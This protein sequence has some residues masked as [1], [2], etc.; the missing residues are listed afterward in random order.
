M[1]AAG[2]RH[3]VASLVSRGRAGGGRC[4]GASCAARIGHALPAWSAPAEGFDFWTVGRRNCKGMG[5]SH[6]GL[7][8]GRRGF[9]PVR[10]SGPMRL[11]TAPAALQQ[12]CWSTGVAWLGHTVAHGQGGQQATDKGFCAAL[13]KP[14]FFGGP[15]FRGSPPP[16]RRRMLLARLVCWILEHQDHGGARA[17]I[18]R[19]ALAAQLD[20]AAPVRFSWTSRETVEAAD[21]VGVALNGRYA[22]CARRRAH[23][24]SGR[25]I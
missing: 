9:V 6:V 17:R 21:G 23:I 19:H 8:R 1:P 11:P 25:E 24:A 2:L 14:T 4:S 15:G 12:A 20:A 13:T 5:W 3:D 10:R 22:A 16:V 18:R 7:E